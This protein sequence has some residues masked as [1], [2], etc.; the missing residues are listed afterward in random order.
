MKE[1]E[2][3]KRVCWWVVGDLE[4]GHSDCLRVLNLYIQRLENKKITYCRE[5]KL[6]FDMLIL[7]IESVVTL[8]RNL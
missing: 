7:V 1:L 8:L 3:V 4:L 5:T 2:I 6:H